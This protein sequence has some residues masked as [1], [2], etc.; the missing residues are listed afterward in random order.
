MDITS[1]ILGQKSGKGSVVIEEGGDYT[2]TDPDNDGNIVI[3]EDDNN[4]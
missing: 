1:Y 2:F 3:Q 4:G